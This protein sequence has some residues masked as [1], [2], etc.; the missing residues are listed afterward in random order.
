MNL[1]LGDL[2]PDFDAVSTQ[3]H[4]RLHDFVGKNWCVFFSHPKDFTPVCTTEIGYMARL[5]REF[6][7]RGVKLLGLSVDLVANHHKWEADI[8]EIMG[9]EV[10]F[11]IVEDPQLKVAKLYGMLHAEAGGDAATRTA[12]DNFTARNLF[13]ISPEKKIRFIVV[14]PMTTGRHFDEILRVI[15]S[16]QIEAQ[17]GLATPAHWMPGD[18]LL[19]PANISYQDAVKRFPKGVK[20][21]K[22]Y[23][24]L[25]PNP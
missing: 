25:T 6:Q 8:V 19:V 9:C 24:K 11:P 22:P 13:I 23:F 4:I 12:A 16:L 5:Q 20:S 15:D 3:G 1:R 14:Y 18:D 10:H 17:H 7:A 2:A 21:I